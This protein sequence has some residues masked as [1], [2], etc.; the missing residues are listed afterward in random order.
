MEGNWRKGTV[1]K[2]LGGRELEQGN[3]RKG[4]VGRKQGLWE[5]NWMKRTGRRK[6]RAASWKNVSR[7]Q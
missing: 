5:G 1:G 3:W 2:E 7:M 4:I 6:L